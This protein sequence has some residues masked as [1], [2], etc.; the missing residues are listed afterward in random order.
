M[1]VTY[2]QAIR[3]SFFDITRTVENPQQLPDAARHIEDGLL[4]LNAGEIVGLYEWQQGQHLLQPGNGALDY[5][6]RLIVPGFVDTHIH[7]PQTEM[8]GAFGEQLLEW[9]NQY[10][11]MLFG[12]TCLSAIGRN[13]R[14][15]NTGLDYAFCR[16]QQGKA[17]WLQKQAEFHTRQV[18][19]PLRFIYFKETQHYC[20]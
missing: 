3:A 1:S 17:F 2:T 13:L 4:L 7:Y 6:G 16:T 12:R 10:P 20:K 19:S 5:R 18:R 9:L 14:L 15:P 11:R 8:I